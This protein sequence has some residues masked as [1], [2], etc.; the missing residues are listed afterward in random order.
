[1]GLGLRRRRRRWNTRTN[2]QWCVES[3]AACSQTNQN[4]PWRCTARKTAVRTAY[5]VPHKTNAEPRRRPFALGRVGAVHTIL[6]H[7]LSRQ[8]ETSF[9]F[10]CSMRLL[11]FLFQLKEASRM[12]F[13]LSVCP[14]A[15][16]VVASSY[17]L[18]R[19]SCQPLVSQLPLWCLGILN[20][21]YV[22]LA[23]QL[24]LIHIWA[25]AMLVSSST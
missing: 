2:I 12:S 13:P 1:L 25:S 14:R 7:A 11:F 5:C 23:L 19:E 18:A 9:P 21:D 8:S 24:E 4:N 20:V 16:S 15:A 6:T 22:L 10:F 3:H 17:A